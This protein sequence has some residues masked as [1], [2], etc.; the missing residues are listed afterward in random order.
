MMAIAFQV[1]PYHWPIIGWMEDIARYTLDDL[2]A[3][4]RTYYNPVNAL[5]VVVGDFDKED[6]LTRVGKAFGTY[7]KGEFPPQ[8]KS[9]EPPQEGE[10]R[11]FVKK[12]AQLPTVLLGYHVPDLSEPDG[13]VLEVIAAILS[14]G[15]SSRFYQ[16]LVQ[17]KRLVLSADADY[18]PLSRDPSLFQLSAELLPEKEVT[19]VV[20]ALEQELERLKREPVGERELEKAKNQLE[21]DFVYGPDSIFYQAMLVARYEIAHGWRRIDDY[22]PSIRRVSP[23]DIQRVVKRYFP[24]DNRTVGILTPLPRKEGK[25]ALPGS[26]GREQMIR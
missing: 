12:Q 8:E 9:K 3:H 4:Y 14:G 18:S 13:Y 23:E 20:K 24:S 15:K 19:G 16:T 6:L 10:R 17:E 25:P 5:L 7:P 2:K 22:L 1:H 11:I 21:A 26:S